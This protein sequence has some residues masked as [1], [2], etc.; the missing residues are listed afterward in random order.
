[1]KDIYSFLRE[2]DET[3]S[4]LKSNAMAKHFARH[5]WKLKLGLRPR[6]EQ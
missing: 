3:G 5:N 4:Q 2:A 1:M 6:R